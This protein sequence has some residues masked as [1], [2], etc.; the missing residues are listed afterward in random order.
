MRWVHTI[1]NVLVCTKHC[2]QHWW[3]SNDIYASTAIKLVSLPVSPFLLLMH[4]SPPS[5]PWSTGAPTTTYE[6]CLSANG[7]TEG[8]TAS[9]HRRR[10][11]ED[12]ETAA[13]RWQVPL[14]CTWDWQI[15]RAW[16]SRGMMSYDITVHLSYDITVCNGFMWDVN[17][18]WFVNLWHFSRN[19]VLPPGTK[20]RI[21]SGFKL[22]SRNGFLMLYPGER[23]M[24]DVMC[25]CGMCTLHCMLLL[26]SYLPWVVCGSVWVNIRT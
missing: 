12:V 22:Q 10:W 18:V 23:E 15:D 5:G 21:K 4:P 11:P 14:Q 6:G 20:I 8:P 25:R 17:V 9:G 7:S 1:D 24:E 16:V 13:H 2:Y 26:Q 19:S 3:Q